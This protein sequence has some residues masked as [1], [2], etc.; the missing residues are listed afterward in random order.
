MKK[1]TI[2]WIIGMIFMLTACV[3]AFVGPHICFDLALIAGSITLLFFAR[4]KRREK[5][6]QSSDTPEQKK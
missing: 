6:E 4:M 5:D 3:F 1:S 2:L